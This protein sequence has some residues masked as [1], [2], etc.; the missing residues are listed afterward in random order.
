MTTILKIYMTSLIS[1]CEAEKNFS[2][3]S[4]IKNKFSSS[5]LKERLNHFAI[6]SIE[7]NT[8]KVLIQR[9]P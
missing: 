7:N 8:T 2:K 6:F 1:S 9:N 4:I 3:P 5:I